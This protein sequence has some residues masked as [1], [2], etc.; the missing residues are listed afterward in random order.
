MAIP[1]GWRSS[2]EP[3]GAFSVLIRDTAV[4]TTW[5]GVDVRSAAFLTRADVVAQL[6]AAGLTST[7]AS[8]T[9]VLRSIA[10]Q[11]TD[12]T[13]AAQVSVNA[14][15]GGAAATIPADA[16]SV[17]MAGGGTASREF[18][19]RVEQTTFQYRAAAA[20]TDVNIEVRFDVPVAS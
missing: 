15:A 3:L 17:A 5:V 14:T 12:A 20:T 13:N 19:T 4:T 8:D 1:S 9:A 18:H 16:F 7:G 11:C 2:R 6:T 10:V